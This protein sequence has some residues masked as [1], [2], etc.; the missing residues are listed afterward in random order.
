MKEESVSSHIL[1]FAIST[2]VVDLRSPRNCEFG[3][4]VSRHTFIHTYICVLETYVRYVYMQHIYVTKGRI[5]DA[6]LSAST[7]L[8]SGAHIPIYPFGQS[9]I[10]RAF[11]ELGL[12]I[13]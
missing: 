9:S 5:G 6:F 3:R 1:V 7:L 12:F 10:V 11:H 13:G 8:L 2:C 4:S